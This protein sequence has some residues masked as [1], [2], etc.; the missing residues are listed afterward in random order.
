MKNFEKVLEIEAL[1]E[2]LTKHLA[3]NN[4]L[5]VKVLYFISQ[6]ENLSV[7]M[8]ID[9]LGVKK[10]NFALM[11]KDLETE[12]LVE[13]KQGKIDRRCRLMTLTEKGQAFLNEFMAK[14]D[15]FFP[16]TDPEIENSV[17]VLTN[18]LNKKI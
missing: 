3:S 6:Y 14:L 18:F 7:S 11:A 2:N 1:T 9:K 17:E 12:G 15:A 8:I 4:L 16:E 13:A 5:K 10:S